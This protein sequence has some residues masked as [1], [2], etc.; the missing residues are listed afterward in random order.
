MC[1]LPNR[2]RSAKWFCCL[3]LFQNGTQSLAEFRHGFAGVTFDNQG[4]E[5]GIGTNQGL[6]FLERNTCPEISRCEAFPEFDG[7]RLGHVK[8]LLDEG[9]VVEAAAEIDHTHV[10]EVVAPTEIAKVDEITSVAHK[11]DIAVLEV[12]VDGSVLVR[13][14]GD[15]TS[16][17]VLFSRRK[18]G[19]FFQQAIVTVLDIFKLLGIY[20]GG[21]EFEA[22]LG[23]FVS[24]LR[25][26]FGLVSCS[27]RIGFLT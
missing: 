27:A 15:E 16:Q 21:M 10:E 12:A 4:F 13:N 6:N 18:E 7:Q 5:A 17:F 25:H 14:V 3:I 26:L 2:T 19:V 23:K 11:D 20:M 24:E 9:L 1:V 8:G 22:H